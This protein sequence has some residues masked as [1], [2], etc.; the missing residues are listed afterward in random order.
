VH[1][2]GFAG[3]GV[4]LLGDVSNEPL[5]AVL[6][7]Q[8]AD[9]RV[10]YEASGVVVRVDGQLAHKVLSGKRH[11]RAARGCEMHALACAVA[12]KHVAPLLGVRERTDSITLIMRYGEPVN[13]AEMSVDAW[14]RASMQLLE[15]LE[16]LH[17]HN[18]VHRDIKPGNLLLVDGRLCLTDFDAS[19]LLLPSHSKHVPTASVAVNVARQGGG[20]CGYYAPEIDVHDRDALHR[21][22]F[23]DDVYAA[24]VTIGHGNPNC[25]L[26]RNADMQGVYE[27]MQ[28]ELAAFRPSAREALVRVR[29][30]LTS[31]RAATKAAKVTGAVPMRGVRQKVAAA[32]AIGDENAVANVR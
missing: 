1:A 2:Y 14:M 16:L 24:G 26:I 8:R 13:F 27:D 21:F 9:T 29:A 25:Y 17:A 19:M 11:A 5:D 3:V 32:G 18:I 31:L 12:P 4:S 6:T 28:L 10:V 7:L 15:G 30:A 22:T 23:A 20:T